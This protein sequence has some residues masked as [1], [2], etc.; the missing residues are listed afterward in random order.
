MRQ[1]SR[2]QHFFASEWLARVW[3]STMLVP[4]VILYRHLVS[5]G[6]DI[7]GRLWCGFGSFLI[8]FIFY[9]FLGGEFLRFLY[10]LLE[11]KNGGPF[12]PGDTVQILHGPH[13]G[14]IARVRFC[15]R[16]HPRLYRVYGFQLGGK[17]N[18][19]I[20]LA[21]ALLREDG[22]EP[23]PGYDVDASF[24]EAQAMDMCA[25][26]RE[27]ETPTVTQ[28]KRYR[29]GQVC[30]VIA[31]LSWACGIASIF[32]FFHLENVS[33][34]APE[35]LLCVEMNNHGGYFYVTPSQSY[36]FDG[37]FSGGGICFL[38]FA[39]LGGFLQGRNPFSSGPSNE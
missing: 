14:R 24:L 22:V 23:S 19:G 4:S 10:Y 9:V 28:T 32:Y 30:M 31:A 21:P 6:D 11:R 39:V 29:A 7:V 8:V 25:V 37:L 34:A 17:E 5:P 15:S 13:K 16:Q 20:F 27:G 33:P 36:L 3:L 38:A 12:Q 2:L 26:T 35:G 1:P 18:E